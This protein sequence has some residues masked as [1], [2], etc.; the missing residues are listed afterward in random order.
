MEKS[1]KLPAGL[2]AALLAE[3]AD[4]VH[5]APIGPK[6]FRPQFLENGR[7]GGGGGKGTPHNLLVENRGRFGSQEKN[8]CV[9]GQHSLKNGANLLVL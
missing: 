1:K 9:L 5:R 3:A 7:N 2:G 4:S 8:I 6:L